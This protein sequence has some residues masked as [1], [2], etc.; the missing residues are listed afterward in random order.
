[1]GIPITSKKSLQVLEGTARSVKNTLKREKIHCAVS[2]LKAQ[3][4][5]CIGGVLCVDFLCIEN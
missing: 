4:V 1:M 2:R 3:T 5:V